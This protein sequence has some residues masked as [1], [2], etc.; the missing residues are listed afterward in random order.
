MTSRMKKGFATRAF[1][2]A[3]TE[4]SFKAG[5][6]VECETGAYDNYAAAGLVADTRAGAKSDGEATPQA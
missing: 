4:Q 6:A 2:D 1:N 5:D 3:G